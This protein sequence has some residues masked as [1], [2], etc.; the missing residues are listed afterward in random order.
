MS[1]TQT[2]LGPVAVK[3]R[4]TRS[5]AGRA[6]LVVRRHEPRPLSA[7]DMNRKERRLYEQVE[8]EADS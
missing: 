8:V 1:A 6:S 5:G 2:W 3:S 4:S 7:R